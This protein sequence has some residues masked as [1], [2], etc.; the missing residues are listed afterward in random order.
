MGD[1][2][3]RGRGGGYPPQHPK[4][5]KDPYA[6][7]VDGENARIWGMVRGGRCQPSARKRWLLTK[8][9]KTWLFLPKTG[10]S[11]Y[12]GGGKVGVKF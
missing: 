7:L 10:E 1:Y 9:G 11:E 3:N 2:V 12:W 8:K 6:H 5:K 4:P